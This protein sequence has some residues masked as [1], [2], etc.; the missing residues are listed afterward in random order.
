[1]LFLYR[2]LDKRNRS[3]DKVRRYAEHLKDELA[4]FVAGKES[5]VKDYSIDLDVQQKAAKEL[6]HKLKLT[7]EELAEKAKAIAKIDERINA[8]DASLEELVRMTGLVQENLDRIGAESVFV[9]TVNKKVSDAR[10]KLGAF[11]KELAGLK[12]R[13]E[14][15]NAAALSKLSNTVL[16][17]IKSSI[18]ALKTEA[19]RVQRNVT[20]QRE[21]IEKTEQVRSANLARDMEA[22]N[23]T[24]REAAERAGV[25]AD[26]MEEAVLAKLKAQSEDRIQRLQHS[27]EENF[28]IHQEHA[29][30]RLA[31]LD[32]IVTRQEESWNTGSKDIEE[33]RQR[34]LEGWSRDVEEVTALLKTQQAEWMTTADE[35]EAHSKQVLSEV[36]HAV[37]NIRSYIVEQNDALE[38]KLKETQTRMDDTITTLEERLTNASSIAE[39]KVMEWADERLGNWRQVALDADANLQKTLAGLEASSIQIKDFFEHECTVLEQRLKDTKKQTEDDIVLLKQQIFNTAQEAE[40]KVSEEADANLEHICRSF[41]NMDKRLTDIQS[42]TND[43]V[44]LIEVR[45]KETAAAAEKRMLE[46]TDRHLEEWKQAAVNTEAKLKGLLH[47]LEIS[48]DVTQSQL[49]T[50]MEHI[51]RQL[52]GAHAHTEQAIAELENSIAKTA[53]AVDAKIAS[54]ADAKL[55]RWL[56]ESENQDT[57]A[58]QI[59]E[60]LEEITAQAKSHFASEIEAFNKQLDEERA[61][62]DAVIAELQD[63]FATEANALDGKIGDADARTNKAIG[64]MD[65]RLNTAC[66]GLK[67]DMAKA[68]STAQAAIAA[69][70]N[71]AEKQN[72]LHIAEL[73]AS[74]TNTKARLGEE[75]AR[76][77]ERMRAFRER[78]EETVTRI[79]AAVSD[80]VSKT[81]I[82]AEHAAN[83]RLVQWKSTFEAEDA[84]IVR[85]LAELEDL[86]AQVKAGINGDIDRIDERNT[87][88]LSELEAMWTQTKEA[89]S[90]ELD[91]VDEQNKARVAHLEVSFSEVKGRIASEIAETESHLHSIEKKVDE[92]MSGIEAAMSTAVANT[93]AKVE[94]AANDR[95]ERWKAAFASGD[96]QHAR[97]LAELEAL[98]AQTKSGITAELER[99][100]EQNRERIA[101]LDASFAETK[102]RIDEEITDTETKLRSIHEEFDRTVSRIENA[103]STAIADSD[104]KSRDAAN[105]RLEQWKAAFVSGDEQTKRWTAELT[106]LLART[107]DDIAMEQE[108]SGEQNRERIAEL[109]ASFAETKSRLETEVENAERQLRYIQQEIDKSSDHI[110]NSIAMSVEDVELRIRTAAEAVNAETKYMLAD[111]ESAISQTKTRFEE[112]IVQSE[113]HLRD[114]QDKL[115]DT[116]STI[117]STMKNAVE[118]AE[119]QSNEKTAAFERKFKEMETTADTIIQ[120]FEERFQ[121]AAEDMEQSVLLETDAKFDEYREAQAEQFQ[122]FELLAEDTVQLEKELRVLLQETEVRVKSDFSTFEITSEEEQKTVLASFTANAES[123]KHEMGSMEQ[124]LAAL[125]ERVYGDVSEKLKVFEDEFATNLNQRTEAVD[126][127]LTEWKQFLDNQLTVI[128]EDAESNRRRIE[129]TYT[130]KLETGLNGYNDRLTAQLEKLKE[131]ADNFE[132][133]IRTQM[134]IADESLFSLKEQFRHDMEDARSSAEAAVRSEIGRHNLVIAD[135]LKQ[136]QREIEVKIKKIRDDIDGRSNEIAGLFETSKNSIDEWKQNLNA[137]LRDLESAL[138]E[139]RKRNREMITESNERMSNVRA[140][141]EDVRMEADAHRAEL[142]SRI[143]EQARS[144]DMAIKEADRHIKE[145][146]AQTSLFERADTL[147]HEFEHHIEDLRDDLDRLDQRRTEAADLENQFIKIKRLEDEVN[148]KMTRFLSEKHRIEQ[149]E[150][151]FNRLLQTSKAVDEKL[152]QLSASD[153]TLQAMQI[154]IRKFN[155]ALESS[156]ERYLRIERK[157]QTLEI[158]NEGID[159]N[160]KTLQE[161]EQTAAR[162]NAELLEL[163]SQVISFRSTLGALAAESEKAKDAADKIKTLDV[164]LTAIDERIASAQASREWLARLETRLEE[165]N[166]Q[167]Q[168]QIKLMGTLINDNATGGSRGKDAPSVG[169]RENVRKLAHQG[170]TVDEI[171]RSLK[172]GRGEVELILELSQKK[173]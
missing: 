50:E 74:F 135:T 71:A 161:S 40:A 115:S 150:T 12:Q 113:H 27:I 29:R 124:E 122:R 66:A 91:R 130:E 8:Y 23:K 11:E 129:T 133:G 2:Q 94:N 89:L 22:I 33:Q 60:E 127:R 63:K 112:E 140:S 149:M 107:K 45:L 61:H 123:L 79:E 30:E 117:E 68:V 97:R 58:K 116:F 46:H 70:C 18:G 164:T 85:R 75:I 144:L 142:F 15:D 173:G 160:F 90:S 83:D 51:R 151:E 128:A 19:E 158:T 165:L 110:K 156:E 41:E 4:A 146:T 101:E 76:A 34:F 167:A 139:A 169:V 24:L 42:K 162:I 3:L 134:Q 53:A 99:A 170:W 21:A 108:R 153:D 157:N 17:D 118:V 32:G 69:E 36:E 44:S 147:K 39:Q 26:R 102:R 119:S 77:E 132:E 80:A 114:I 98:A 47:E 104:A 7:E 5:A 159:R 86:F 120:K 67:E 73:D 148:A 9:E 35:K 106:A 103:V 87:Q 84:H 95:L 37:A 38:Q 131:D 125:K 143:D 49:E 62:T 54:E 56:H 126:Q 152:A 138:E 168:E 57:K 59:L 96:E 6:M 93:D 111:V 81:D 88:R 155:D 43:A 105:D 121:K 16:T 145:F 109:D 78:F 14:R 64:D 141:I 72:K 163:S 31:E 137:Q 136:N 92:T 82:K 25:T 65:K 171:A 20:E 172:I 1:V 55:V 13:F 10:D 166:K 100:G 52:D 48:H 154:E 28:R